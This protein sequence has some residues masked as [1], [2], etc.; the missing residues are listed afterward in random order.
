VE[1]CDLPPRQ[2]VAP[3]RLLGTREAWMTRHADLMNSEEFTK[4]VVLMRSLSPFCIL[5]IDPENRSRR[6]DR[7]P[8]ISR[9]NLELVLDGHL[10]AV[11]LF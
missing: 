8:A 11:P 7:C 1:I 2:P 6:Q 4:F 9:R 10:D 3:G 5:L